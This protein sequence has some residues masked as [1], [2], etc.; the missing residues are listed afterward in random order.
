MDM[1]WLISNWRLTQQ[2]DIQWITYE[3]ESPFRFTIAWSGRRD[4]YVVID[5]ITGSMSSGS[6]LSSDVVSI[7]DY[8]RIH[9]ASKLNVVGRFHS[10]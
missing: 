2:T 9:D 10:S 6:H 7:I 1:G 8:W 4:K 5:M 3:V